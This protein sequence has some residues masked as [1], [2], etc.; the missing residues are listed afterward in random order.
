MFDFIHIGLGKCMSTY[1]Q[2]RWIND[3]NYHCVTCND[4]GVALTEQVLQELSNNEIKTPHLNLPTGSG[5]GSAVLTGEVLS[6]AFHKSEALDQI[7][8]KKKQRH[9]ASTFQGHSQKILIIVRS[10][11]TWVKSCHA[12]MI[13]EGHSFNLGRFVEDYGAAIVNNLDLCWLIKCWSDYGFDSVI[14]PLETL[15]KNE[16]AF[17]SAYTE[18]LGCKEPMEFA[19]SSQPRMGSIANNITDY[20]SLRLHASVNG[21][22]NAL[23]SLGQNAYFVND[24]EKKRVLE[25]IDYSKRWATRRIIPSHDAK[26]LQPLDNLLSEGCEDTFFELKL[27]VNFKKE[28]ENRFL[29][30]LSEHGF[31]DAIIEAYINEMN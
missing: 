22:L 25:A 10:P 17:W 6:S 1:M 12:Q 7:V 2:N 4:I 11:M 30:P 23:E 13:H 21:I 15:R 3:P 27:P 19:S 31:D 26:A 18:Q 8:F 20:G 16:Q 9:V 28:I 24:I 29:V 14:L 5:L